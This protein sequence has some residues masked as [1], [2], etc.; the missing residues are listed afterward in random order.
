MDPDPDEVY[1]GY[2][3][4]DECSHNEEEWERKYHRERMMSQSDDLVVLSTADKLALYKRDDDVEFQK[5]WPTVEEMCCSLMNYSEDWEQHDH[6]IIHKPSKMRYWTGSSFYCNIT[7]T[8]NGGN[9]KTVFSDKQGRLIRAAANYWRVSKL[10]KEQIAVVQSFRPVR[11]QYKPEPGFWGN[12][13]V[14][15]KFLPTMARFCMKR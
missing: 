7:E 12:L 13:W 11:T 14:S 3:S 9:S 5:M 8:Y 2:E 4:G 6:Y 15:I 1:Y 10:S